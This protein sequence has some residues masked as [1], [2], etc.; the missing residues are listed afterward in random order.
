M[1][2]NKIQLKKF[3]GR[4]NPFAIQLDKGGYITINREITEDDLQDHLNGEKTYGTYVI[5][6]DGLVGFGV[7]DIDGELGEPL[8][9]LGLTCYKLFPDFERV[10]EFSGRKGYHIW[11]FPQ[12]LETPRFIRELKSF[13]YQG[14]LVIEREIRGP[15]QVKDITEAIS[16]LEE[17]REA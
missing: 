7:I 2:I 17:L 14:P 16:L 8:K 12:K 4:K 5:R 9:A 15:E 11:I 13:N 6:E 10:L 1:K 3:I